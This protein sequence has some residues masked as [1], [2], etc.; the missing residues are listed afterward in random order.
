MTGSKVIDSSVWLEYFT[1]GYYKE[2]IESNEVLAVAAI[3]IFEIK[4]KLLKEAIEIQTVKKCIHFI[5][6]R[7]LVIDLTQEIAEMAAE[8]AIKH[9]LP[10]ADAIIYTSAMINQS[11]LITADNDFR[12]LAGVKVV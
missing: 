7:S 1:N 9:R 10:A 3:S 6:R 2:T 8:I 5:K 4:K 12:G 11:E